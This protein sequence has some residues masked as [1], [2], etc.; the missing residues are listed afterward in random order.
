MASVIAQT[1]KPALIISHNK[2]LAA[3]LTEEFKEFF[4]DNAVEYFVSYYDYYQPE[5]YIPRTDTYISKDASINEEIDRLRHAA[6]EAILTRKDVIVVASVSCIYGLGTPREY[7]EARIEIKPGQR[8]DRKELILDLTRLQYTRNDTDFSRGT[9][10][11]RGDTIDIH[12][13]GED[14]IIR[15]EFFGNEIER[16]QHLDSLTGHPLTSKT[17]SDAAYVFP[18]TFFV[19]DNNQRENALKAIRDELKDRVEKTQ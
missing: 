13:S 3:Q 6:M 16:I 7:M 8:S 5:A 10:R 12:P 9:F 14:H 15:V 2:T 4:P 11:V 18:A 17:N 1:N 19:I